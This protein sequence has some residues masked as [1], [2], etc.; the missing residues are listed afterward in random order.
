[1]SSRPLIHISINRIKGVCM[2]VCV[3]ATRFLWQRL[4]KDKVTS[5]GKFC[6]NG[7][8]HESQNE[9]QNHTWTKVTC[10]SYYSTNFEYLNASVYHNAQDM[11][12]KIFR[13]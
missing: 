5:V 8:V 7:T 13:V 2:W 12:A 10:L 11:H 1:M 6:R 3:C 4:R 9:H